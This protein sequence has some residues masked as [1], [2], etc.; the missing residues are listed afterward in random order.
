MSRVADLR[1]K[2]VVVFAASPWA[3][4][5]DVYLKSGGLTRD[6]VKIDVVDAAALF[7]ACTARQARIERPDV[8]RK[9]SAARCRSSRRR[10]L[11]NVCWL[12]TP[13]SRFP[14]YWSGRPGEGFHRQQKRGTPPCIG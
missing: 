9:G 7:G 12:P 5:I 3:P 2:T 8:D 14:S 10:G 4:F 11:R 6:D 13:A 1:G